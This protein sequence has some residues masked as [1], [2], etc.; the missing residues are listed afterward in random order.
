MDFVTVCFDDDL[1]QLKLQASSMSV[2]LKNFPV[3]TIWLCINSNQ[4]EQ[5]NQYI[6]QVMP[7]YGWLKSKVKIINGQQL[8]PTGKDGY[9]NQMQ[10]KILIAKLISTDWYCI[11]DAKNFLTAEWTLDHIV[12]DNKYISVYKDKNFTDDIECVE[13]SFDYL[14]QN[15]NTTLIE[16]LTPFFIKTQISKELSKNQQLFDDWNTVWPAEFYLM[17]AQYIQKGC[18][19]EDIY[20]DKKMW[21]NGIWFKCN[22]LTEHYFASEFICFGIHRKA[23]AT[24]SPHVI[25]QLKQ[26]C[27]ELKIY[28]PTELEII[29]NEMI[30]L[31]PWTS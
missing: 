19:I 27:Q 12:V 24:L 11:L 25:E 2:F 10:L 30:R 5:C 17:Q 4:F 28:N 22:D 20:F 18:N 15:K 14:N 26:L 8:D 6:Q 1:P 3:D 13:R 9:T 29:I 7:Y 23:F 31:N 16:S 21:R